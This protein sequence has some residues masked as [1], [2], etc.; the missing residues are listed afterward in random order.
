[1]KIRIQ[2][3]QQNIKYKQEKNIT[4]SDNRNNTKCHT[5]TAHIGHA[6]TVSVNLAVLR[7]RGVEQA[8]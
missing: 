4:T 2:F 5:K 1:M 3:W 6:N 7:G 8:I